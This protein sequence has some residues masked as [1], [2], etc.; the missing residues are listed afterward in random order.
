MH[1]LG[2]RLRTREEA[3]AEERQQYVTPHASMTLTY[4]PHRYEQLASILRR[5]VEIGLR[6][7]GWEEVQDCSPPQ[8]SRVQSNLLQSMPP[9]VTYGNTERTDAPS[10][11]SDTVLS[12]NDTQNIS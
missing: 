5:V 7:G 12:S 4:Q 6:G 1:E 10:Y 3:A 2:E 8:L 9:S 11:S